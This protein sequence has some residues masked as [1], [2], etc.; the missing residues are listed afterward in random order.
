MYEVYMC[1]TIGRRTINRFNKINAL[2]PGKIMSF[3]EK[4]GGFLQIAQRTPICRTFL[5]AYDHR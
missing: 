5:Y 3:S 2:S 4:R 1:H